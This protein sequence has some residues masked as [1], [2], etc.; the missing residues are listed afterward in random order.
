MHLPRE[1]HLAIS[2][3]LL[4]AAQR[5]DGVR[6]ITN[7]DLYHVNLHWDRKRTARVDDRVQEV[8]D[9]PSV[10]TA[11]WN[12]ARPIWKLRMALKIDLNSP[13]RK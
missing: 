8:V 4:D 10:Q 11:I 12:S 6:P 3:H 13:E 1:Y 2:C 9:P 7:E 5:Y